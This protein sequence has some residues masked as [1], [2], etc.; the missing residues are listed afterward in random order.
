MIVNPADPHS[1]IRTTSQPCLLHSRHLPE[2][3]VNHRHH[4]WPLGEGGPDIED[5]IVVVCAT[6]HGN[7]H[8]L[9]RHFKMLGGKV[10]YQI[11][12]RYS[13]KEREFAELGY[14]RLIRRAM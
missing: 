13:Y 11:L 3:H 12:R 5:N 2:T 9:L 4:I 10:P 8:D 6:G 14:K 1:Q 7:I